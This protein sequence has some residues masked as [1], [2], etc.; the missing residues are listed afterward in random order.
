MLHNLCISCNINA[1]YYPIFNDTHNKDQFINCY[2]SQPL[3]YYLDYYEEI[4]KPCHLSCKNCTEFGDENNNK[5]TECFN[6]FYGS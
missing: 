5:C 1:K 3:G 4:Y 2:N 6:L